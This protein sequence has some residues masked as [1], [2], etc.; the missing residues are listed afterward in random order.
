MV[1]AKKFHADKKLEEYTVNEINILSNMEHNPHIIGYFDML[2]SQTNFYFV[3][4]YCNG[5]TLQNLLDK[6]KKLP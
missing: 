1:E 5:G 4:E 6:Q 3:Y 2:K